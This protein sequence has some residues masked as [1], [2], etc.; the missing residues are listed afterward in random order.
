[1]KGFEGHYSR[2]VTLQLQDHSRLLQSGD[3]ADAR[4]VINNQ[5]VRRPHVPGAQEID[6]KQLRT[7]GMERRVGLRPL[8]LGPP[9]NDRDSDPT[10]TTLDSH[11]EGVAELLPKVYGDSE[12]SLQAQMEFRRFLQ[13][14]ADHDGVLCKRAALLF[15]LAREKEL[16][17][18]FAQQE[19]MV[20][21]QDGKPTF[22]EDMKER[23]LPFILPRYMRNSCQTPDTF[24]ALA[25]ILSEMWA[26][27]RLGNWPQGTA[28]AGAGSSSEASSA[29]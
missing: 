23:V 26:G 3:R 18:F 2:Q 22:A 16:G 27:E 15:T 24:V 1:M 25:S 6:S 11:L 7:E 19:R 9:L 29:Q 28:S 12:A 20:Q 5:T 10:L 21:G 14:P 17:E 4:Y 13:M 8:L